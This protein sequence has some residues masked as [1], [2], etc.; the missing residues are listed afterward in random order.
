MSSSSATERTP[1]VAV[2]VDFARELRAEGI[3]AGDDDVL[4]FAAAASTLD[5]ADIVD[6]Y[7]AGRASLLSRRADIDTFDRVFRRFFLGADDAPRERVYPRADTVR[8]AESVFEVPATE[9]G[10]EGEDDEQTRLGLLA[11]NVE[12]L[13]HKSFAACTEEELRAL[14]RMMAGMR[15]SPPMRP[16]RRNIGVR[17][18]KRPDPRRT[19]RAALR[20]HGELAEVWWQRRQLRPRPIV[21]ILDISG[22]MADYS[23]ALLQFAYSA[24]RAVA[25]V[26]VFCFGTRLSHLTRALRTRRPDEALHRA[27]RTVLDWEG[28]TRI[29]DSLDAFVRNWGRR[30]LA[31]GGIVV[32][33]S[34]G[35]DRGDP[36]VLDTAMRRL[37]RLCHRVVWLNPLG[38]S[39]S[40]ALGMMVASEYVDVS[41]GGGDLASL[42]ELAKLLPTLN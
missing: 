34:D 14:R 37:T 31:R 20:R 13:K 23:R 16:T 7:W 27:A 28:G 10:A 40:Q 29:G 39:G 1:L 26:E 30:G 12:T 41:L 5:P 6:L 11:S 2:L 9:P 19:V 21:L 35:L 33:C 17:N 18:G 4:T 25:R 24:Q 38:A 32:I 22:S 15:L 36:E 8:A 42:E 3:R